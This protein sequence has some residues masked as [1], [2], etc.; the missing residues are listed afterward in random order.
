MGAF[1][2]GII[3]RR[4]AL[5]SGFYF[6]TTVVAALERYPES[7]SAQT[8]LSTEKSARLVPTAVASVRANFPPDIREVYALR[9]ERRLRFNMAAL[10][11][12]FGRTGI[13]TDHMADILQ[14]IGV[15]RSMLGLIGRLPFAR[16]GILMWMGLVLRPYALSA[17]IVGWYRAMMSSFESPEIARLIAQ[18]RDRSM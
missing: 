18:A 9:L 7:L 16:V 14:F 17:I 5:E 3:V 6:A 10:W 1:S 2:D 4:L 11:L 13:N 8:A 15:T 12:A